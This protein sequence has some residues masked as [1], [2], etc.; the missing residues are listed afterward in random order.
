MRGSSL[1]GSLLVVLATCHAHANTNKTD[2]PASEAKKNET[3]AKRQNIAYNYNPNV[4]TQF[5]PDGQPCCPTNMFCPGRPPCP[6]GLMT[7][8]MPNP[9]D[10]SLAFNMAPGDVQ[11]ATGPQ[12]PAAVFASPLQDAMV[13]P[14][15]AQIPLHHE[16]DKGNQ[17]SEPDRDQVYHIRTTSKRFCLSG[18]IQTRF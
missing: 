3:E 7:P 15:Q 9:L 13:K 11:L 18:F 16:N 2:T 8:E 10:P 14:T 17:K 6:P 1:L 12:Q 5:G 4:M